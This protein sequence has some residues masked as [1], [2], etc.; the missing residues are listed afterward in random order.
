MAYTSMTNEGIK[1][2]AVDINAGRVFTSQ[3]CKRNEVRRVFPVLMFSER[4]ELDRMV[5][6]NIVVVYEYLDQAAPMSANGLPIFF[7]ARLLDKQDWKRLV[8][9]IKALKAAVKNVE[10]PNGSDVA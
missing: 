5:K 1:K 9:C 6:D 10:E 4:K 3:H 2:L 7:G 8:A